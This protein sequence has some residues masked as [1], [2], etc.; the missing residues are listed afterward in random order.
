MVTEECIITSSVHVLNF[1][2]RT[3]HCVNN[4]DLQISVFLS[5]RTYIHLFEILV[6]G[7]NLK[8]CTLDFFKYNERDWL[9]LLQSY[10][11]E[12]MGGHKFVAM[13][14][15]QLSLTLILRPRL[16]KNIL[17]LL[18]S[19]SYITIYFPFR[20]ELLVTKKKRRSAARIPYW[21]TPFLWR[22][23]ISVR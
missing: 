8:Q 21:T 11:N 1:C 2:V 17:C 18:F 22:F 4:H 12:M 23:K 14:F 9:T 7:F 10:S 19:S 6:T 5:N 16:V 15:Q 13:Q 3:S 20:T